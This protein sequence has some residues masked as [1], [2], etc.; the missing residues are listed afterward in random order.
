MC[1]PAVEGAAAEDA[2]SSYR[3]VL[4]YSNKTIQVTPGTTLLSALRAAGLDPAT[5]CE[6]GICGTC[7]T[8]VLEGRPDH[9]DSVLSAAERLA[10]KSMMIC[11]SGCK[12]ESLV[13]AL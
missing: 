4:S 11:V 12:S 7:E 10:N 3:V 2:R 1:A 8:R 9:R 13:L 5:S 6:E